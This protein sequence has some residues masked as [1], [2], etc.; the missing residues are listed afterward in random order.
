MA[1]ESYLQKKLG[2]KGG[3]RGPEVV[4]EKGLM[5]EATNPEPVPTI[6]DVRE[7]ARRAAHEAFRSQRSFTEAEIAASQKYLTDHPNIVPNMAAALRQRLQQNPGETLAEIDKAMEEIL[8]LP[9][10]ANIDQLRDSNILIP[11]LFADQARQLEVN[12]G[13]LGAKMKGHE[14]GKMKEPYYGRMML[15]TSGA[16]ALT[17]ASAVIDAMFGK[18]G[19][20]AGLEIA[21]EKLGDSGFELLGTG[22]EWVSS[23]LIETT[24]TSD[25]AQTV[26]T[27]INAAALALTTGALVYAGK[28]KMEVKTLRGLVRGKV[29]PILM[30][31]ILIGMTTFG[32]AVAK[33]NAVESAVSQEVAKQIETNLKKVSSDVKAS[34]QKVQDVG[35]IFQAGIQE[36]SET[37]FKKGGEGFGSE[38]A[39]TELFLKGDSPEL[40]Q[41]F[42]AFLE[43]SSKK[44]GDKEEIE[45]RIQKH[46]DRLQAAREAHAKLNAK[47]QALLP[48]SKKLA[49]NGGADD[50]LDIVSSDLEKKGTDFDSLFTSLLAVSK[51]KAAAGIFSNI[52]GKL[53][54]WKAHP[55]FAGMLKME[56][57]YHKDFAVIEDQIRML[58]LEQYLDE[59]SRDS[60]IDLRIAVSAPALAITSAEL[61]P[62]KIDHARYVH[63]TNPS[64][65]AFV[66]P[67]PNQAEWEAI[68]KS[69][70]KSD[71]ENSLEKPEAFL[72]R[73]L[74][75][76]GT[77][78]AFLFFLAGS[79][80]G[81]IAANRYWERRRNTDLEADNAELAKN[82]QGMVDTVFSY[83]QAYRMQFAGFLGESV[84]KDIPD[85]LRSA[86]QTRLR[87]IAL[88]EATVGL[89][90]TK[91]LTSRLTD[92]ERNGFLNGTR[93]LPSKS[94]RNAYVESLNALN[95]KITE[96]PETEIP[97]ILESI[98]SQLSDVVTAMK[99]A[100]IA[101][102][103]TNAYEKAIQQMRDAYR[104]F[105]RE[106][107]VQQGEELVRTI[108][109]LYARKRA[110]EEI[111]ANERQET[112]IV[113]GEGKMPQVTPA[114][115][116]RSYMLLEIE[117]EIAERRALLGEI[118]SS[119]FTVRDPGDASATLPQAE[120][121][122][123]RAKFF[124]EETT[125]MFG[126][127]TIAEAAAKVS[128]YLASLEPFLQSKK[129]E[130]D[131]I[132]AQS[133]YVGTARFEY[134]Y[135][136]LHAVRGP[137]IHLELLAPDSS[138]I[139][140]I[141]FGGILPNPGG[142][143]TKDSQ[144]A[145]EKW[146]A[147]DGPAVQKLQIWSAFEKT[148][149]RV[150]DLENNLASLGGPNLEFTYDAN[151]SKT[152]R[153]IDEYL[154]AA[155]Y[156]FEQ[157]KRIHT[158]DTGSPLTKHEIGLFLEPDKNP[159]TGGWSRGRTQT[160]LERIEQ[161][162]VN[163]GKDVQLVVRAL[164]TGGR[165]AEVLIVPPGTTPPI[166]EANIVARTPLV[167]G[168]SA[169][170]FNQLP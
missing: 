124:A 35:P 119:G 12:R 22:I 163:A 146:L 33:K 91:E 157:Q 105:S 20:T 52:F 38:N 19:I 109:N 28:V 89:I 118:Q 111:I 55:S 169:I 126:T 80:G 37:A 141:P 153:D 103:G 48:G 83:L 122:A 29:R 154:I 7:N 127:A 56:D 39:I 26:A 150:R 23:Y 94:L 140:S 155:E 15:A 24:G 152:A 136:A 138:I 5:R 9:D 25:G 87:E 132:I 13:E 86:V 60:G 133:A 66:N 10:T 31:A 41:K 131:A 61:E 161:A 73:G 59:A 50:V 90:K 67:V 168:L 147:P 16:L 32:M 51:D 34:L 98:N 104:R 120:W 130:I 30:P 135:N 99:D 14:V 81:S 112:D 40:Q 166:D 92:D 18:Q 88:E 93:P 164:A 57:R 4:V 97:K 42:D 74:F 71:I 115:L 165:R 1:Q 21:S 117:M 49:A 27:G 17:A 100:I 53:E 6:D 121:D 114:T 102:K 96:D 128:E 113:L 68:A 143:T 2:K 43:A 162:R 65:I 3:F 70:S 139:T 158:L 72:Q 116:V 125:M 159:I 142:D 129:T 145:L 106:A 134:S 85:A 77:A 64:A 148:R 62:Y 69:V 76:G 8:S 46:R 108:E 44:P 82:E 75:I 47:Y 36:R 95:E 58:L 160:T 63:I 11:L 123:L 144:A 137:T 101:G 54:F 79:V 45:R 170:N 167:R 156:L 107:M 151:F 149:D 110:L 84:A 78:V